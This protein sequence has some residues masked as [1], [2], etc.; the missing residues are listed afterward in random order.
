[1]SRPALA[2]AAFLVAVLLGFA[3]L[4]KT[5]AGDERELAYSLGVAPST[6]AAQI[7]PGS[8]TC[9]EP[10]DLPVEAS[11]IVFPVAT[12]GRPGQPLDVTVRRAS[13]RVLGRARVPGGYVDGTPQVAEL[14]RAVGPEGVVAVCIGNRGDQPVFIYGSENVTS[15]RTIT[16]G[17]PNGIDLDL[18]FLRKDPRSFADLLPD[19]FE[20][21]ALFRPG[22]VGAWVYWLL[23]GGL[24]LAAPALLAFAL[25]RAVREDDQGETDSTQSSRRSQSDS[26]SEAGTRS[27]SGSSAGSSITAS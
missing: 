3:W 4:A 11:S 18:R 10:I 16:G 7:E 15:S 23:L 25:V 5:A 20:R 19:A 1:M 9:Q 27:S 26:A 12:D 6:I 14:N 8:R 17:V 13:G 24:A 21:A 22:W 2:G